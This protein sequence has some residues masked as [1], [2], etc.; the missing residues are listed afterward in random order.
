[1]VKH[2]GKK[3][4]Q[5][6]CCNNSLSEYASIGIYRIQICPICRSGF[7]FPRQSPDNE[8][9]PEQYYQGEGVIQ[10]TLF[11]IKKL[12]IYTPR[13]KKISKYK[14]QGKILDFGCGDGSF[15]ETFS[16]KRWDRYGIDASLSAY[17]LSK[18]RDLKVD[19]YKSEKLKYADQFFDVIT[20]NH[21]LEHLE[22]PE[23]ILKELK[24][25]LKDDGILYLEL[26]RFDGFWSRTFKAEWPSNADI[27]RHLNH[28]SHRGLILLL[29]KSG[30]KVTANK[31]F[32]ISDY[33]YLLYLM[34]RYIYQKVK[35]IG[36]RE[37]AFILTSPLFIPLI[38]FNKESIE[39][40]FTKN[41]L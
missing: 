14:K 6:L 4:R 41:D 2:N 13:Q 12:F 35:L 31:H 32:P 18:K 24:R 27:P 3:G 29:E 19:C 17:K 34:Q 8:F 30:F 28:F 25:I 9:Y 33:L 21:V 20:L 37:L 16:V 10:K 5:C 22:I 26:P 39:I 7:T 11:R 15:L 23:Q 1:M 36:A 40:V 38:F